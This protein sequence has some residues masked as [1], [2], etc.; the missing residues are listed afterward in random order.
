MDLFGFTAGG[1]NCFKLLTAISGVGPEGGS[2][3]SVRADAGGTWQWLPLREIPNVC[4]GERRGARSLP[5][6]HFGAQ[7]QGEGFFQDFRLGKGTWCR[8][9]VC[10]YSGNTQAVKRPYHVGLFSLGGR[11]RGGKAGFNLPPEA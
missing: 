2:R 5:A 4:Q 1:L 7:G 10:P 3:H 11:R 9:G 6:Y 8:L